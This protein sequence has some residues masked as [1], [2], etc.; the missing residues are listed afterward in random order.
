MNIKPISAA[1]TFANSQP[2]KQEDTKV[3]K[4][5]TKEEYSYKKEQEE[6]ERRYKEEQIKKQQDWEAL[7]NKPQTYKKD[8]K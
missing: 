4:T 6:R 2:L 1:I 3:E 8:T 5:E 7:I